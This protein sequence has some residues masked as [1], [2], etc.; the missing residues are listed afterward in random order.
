M[1]DTFRPAPSSPNNSR[2]TIAERRAVQLPPTEAPL[3]SP[4]NGKFAVPDPMPT[5]D[6]A[7]SSTDA[8][9]E[10]A[11]TPREENAMENL[12]PVS[13]SAFEAAKEASIV[14]LI[15]AA[16]PHKSL[17]DID[18]IYAWNSAT[19][20]KESSRT[21]LRRIDRNA[22]L[23]DIIKPLATTHYTV[24]HLVAEAIQRERDS[25]QEKTKRLQIEYAELDEEWQEHCKFLDEQMEKRGP[26]PAELFAI[27]HTMILPVTTPG[28]G[29]IPTTPLADDAFGRGNRRRGVGDAVTTEAEFQEIL[30]GLADTAAKDPNYRASK[31]TA[32]VP[33]ML[34]GSERLMRYDD[35]NDLVTDPLAFYD[36]AG[37]AEPIWTSEER[38]AFL[39]RYLNFPKQFGKIAE[40]LPDKTASDCVLYY[41]RTKKT[42]D[43]KGML[44][45]RRGVTKKKAMPIK[46]SGKSS[47]LLADLTRQKPTI[48]P[49]ADVPGKSAITPARSGKD[50]RGSKGRDKDTT[51]GTPGVESAIKRRK[52]VDLD[53]GLD[54]SEGPSRAGSETPA[55]R[56]KLR[57]T[58]KGKRPRVSSIGDPTR[59]ASQANVN[60]TAGELM[61]GQPQ[62]DLLPPVKRAGKRRKVVEVIDPNNPDVTLP[63][64][65]PPAVSATAPMPT[66]GPGD[67]PRRAATNSYWSVD[68]KRR[69]RELQAQFGDDIKS[70]ADGL[71]G[72]SV[73]QV[74]NFLEANRDGGTGARDDDRSEDRL[75]GPVSSALLWQ[76]N[77]MARTDLRYLRIP[78]SMTSTL[79]LVTAIPLIERMLKPS[80]PARFLDPDWG[81]SHRVLTSVKLHCLRNNRLLVFSPAATVLQNIRLSSLCRVL[82]VC[83]SR[84]Y[85]MT[86]RPTTLLLYL[87]GTTRR[88]IVW[89]QS[90]QPQMGRSTKKVY[91]ELRRELSLPDLFN[92]I[93]DPRVVTQV[94][95]L[96]H[97]NTVRGKVKVDPISTAIEVHPVVRLLTPITLALGGATSLSHRTFHL[98]L[99]EPRRPHRIHI[100]SAVAPGTATPLE[101]HTILRRI[102]ILAT[103][104]LMSRLMSTRFLIPMLKYIITHTYTLTLTLILKLRLF[105]RHTE[106]IRL[107]SLL[108]C[109]YNQLITPSI[110][111]N[112]TL[113][114][115][116]H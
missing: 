11:Q 62:S 51:V 84:R 78:A 16:D 27:P 37:T 86:S 89:R 19:V 24:S 109:R 61:N 58:M 56:G 107:R 55:L 15:K 75:N 59:L 12:S 100:R 22:Q 105:L 34:L 42:I 110:I 5:A 104:T 43:Y 47:A 87:Y 111:S 46:K 112:S 18:E 92:S 35:D 79:Q 21:P 80:R 115:L 69:F 77:F 91:P 93:V 113:I 63:N 26:P 48:N 60:G 101:H 74:G 83:V 45:S 52:G 31:T 82:V 14:A 96:S 20:P 65:L 6:S 39:R 33:D 38:A 36:F 70:I 103:R 8:E 57:M 64:G 28:I 32:V 44:A 98:H 106:L 95:A 90:M 13:E 73:R 10:F 40:A 94:M 30:A 23:D 72:K 102:D 17:L 50:S 81:C 7:R 116:R 4:F 3:T 9:I 99:P 2:G 88:G 53:D 97:M 54:S 41:Y 67:K 66:P 29:P 114:R 25:L 76:I 71:P 108:R 85:S 1:K 49:A 68:E